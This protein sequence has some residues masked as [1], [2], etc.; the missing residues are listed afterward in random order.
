MANKAH[1]ELKAGIL[2]L[3]ALAVLVGVVLWLGAA[4][5]LT[6]R[7]QTVVF[8]AP[9]NAGPLGLTEGAAV[10]INDAQVGRVTE[11]RY[12]PENRRTLYVARLSRDDIRIHSNAAAEVIAPLIGNP[13]I[14]IIRKGDGEAIADGPRNAIPIAVGGLLGNLQTTFAREM[15][16]TDPASLLARVKGVTAQLQ[17]AAQRVDQISQMVLTQVDPAAADSLMAGLHRSLSDVNAMTAAIRQQLSPDIDTGLL[18][19]ILR[20]ADELNQ[21][22]ARL[23]AETDAA[24]REALLAKIHRS[25]DDINAMTAEARPGVSR[26]VKS[27]AN[28]AE[29]IEGYTR[30]DVAEVLVKV[31]EINDKVLRIADDFARVSEQ[32]K[33]VVVTNRPNIDELLDNMT[34]LSANLKATGQEVRRAPW[35][36]FYRPDEDERRSQ[37]IYDAARAFS[38]GAE[39]LDQAL[40]KLKKLQELYPQG[41]SGEDPELK[42]I[43]AHLAEVF[44]RFHKAEQALWQELSK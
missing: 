31:R 8:Y 29:M 2:T 9:E 14:S 22:M 37:D 44:K 1:S 36:L 40:T 11:I 6:S 30:K 34:Q 35:K 26:I 28:T 38:T 39:Q 19:K 15:D 23:A 42:Q 5:W 43:R 10:N 33:E 4:Q 13:V 18:A 24:R 12:D 17:L 3:V 32:A 16:E 27:A 20:A 25:V 7:G 41:I 21:M